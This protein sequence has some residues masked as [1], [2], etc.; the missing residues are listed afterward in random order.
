MQREDF[1]RVI[2]EQL[3]KHGYTQASLAKRLHVSAATVN[4]W[5]KG[6]NTIP[7]E[8]ILAISNHW[9]LTGAEQE[10]LFR[11]A[12][13]PL[14]PRHGG[15]TG[16]PPSTVEVLSSDY[17]HRPA[18]FAT[19][20]KS[21]LRK[22]ARQLTA[23]TSALKG[24]GGYGK[25]TLAKA[26]CHDPEIQAAF[27]DG[28][29]WITLGEA[30]K[31]GELIE[32]IKD[33]IY[34][35]TQMRPP[36]ESLEVANAELCVALE[37]RCLLLVVDDVWFASD[38]NP[39]LQ[40]GQRCARLVTTRNEGILPPSIP[41]VQV[42]AMRQEEAVQLLYHRV[43][44]SDDFNRHERA[45]YNLV[46]RL[47][48]WPLLIRL[49]NGILRNR[50]QK[51]N[52]ALSAALAYLE[53]ELDKHGV[54]AF[55]P[56]Q[57]HERHDAVARTLKISFAL[58]SGD[59]YARY[60]KLAIFPEDAEIPFEMV[61]RLWN[62]NDALDQEDVEAICLRLYDLSLLH[63]I[64]L[65]QQYIQLHDV[66]R[67]YLHVK[68]R[69]TL[70]LL[71]QEFLST[72]GLKRWAELSS[73]DT[74]LWKHLIS[75]LIQAKQPDVLFET[76]TDIRYL[77]KKISVYHSAYAAE[78][79]IEYA[80]QA[81]SEKKE[82][83]VLRELLARIGDLLYLCE[84]LSELE[85]M[86]LLYI[87][88]LED[89]SAQCQR[90]R[91]EI[92]RPYLLPWYPFPE[93]KGADL[94]RTL[95]GHTGPVTHCALS[96]D[97]AWI[98]SASAD[99][100]LNVWNMATGALRLTLR[101]HTS[102]ITGCAI[103]PDGSRIISTSEDG[104]IRIWNAYSGSEL[105]VLAEHQGV[106][107]GCALSRDGAWL[108]TTSADTTIKLWDIRTIYGPPTPQGYAV[109]LRYTLQGHD[110]LV[111]SCAFSA[112]GS[113]LV[114]ASED[115]TL[116][117]W[118]IE[119]G[120][121]ILPPV[122][123][124]ETEDIIYSCA[125]SADGTCLIFT[126]GIGLA[127]WD[128]PTRTERFI[129]YGHP[130]VLLGCAL[131][132][133][134]RW[135]LSASVDGSIKGW[136]T[137]QDVDIFILL[138]HADSVNYCA[139][140]AQSD[141][142][143]SASDDHTL[144]IWS[145]PALTAERLPDE[146][147]FAFAVLGCAID[148]SGN[149]AASVAEN[150]E[151]KRWNLHQIEDQYGLTNEAGASAK[152]VISP[153]GKWIATANEYSL[154]LWDA[155]T[156][157]KLQIFQG[158]TGTINHCAIS[159]DGTWLVTASDDQTLRIWDRDTGQEQ[160]ILESHTGAV[161]SCAISADGKR[162]VSASDDQTLNIWDARTGILQ[163]TLRGH[164]E[165]VKD[166]AFTPAGDTIVSASHNGT[167][168]LWNVHMPET[169]PRIFR[170]ADLIKRCVIS[171]DGK[172]LLTLTSTQI[173]LWSLSTGHC[174][175]TFYVRQSLYDCAFHPDGQHFIAAA[176]NGL[177]LLFLVYR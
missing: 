163:Q 166:C 40:G 146:E 54:T 162:I 8:S 59:D 102:A 75:H 104:T 3:K 91:Q 16:R 164:A 152:C 20:K 142:V 66:I 99:T 50:V 84:S 121:Q 92:A 43:G 175:T 73:E 173:K 78:S 57:P 113:L 86:L 153:D 9:Q 82:L 41:G 161:N 33:L 168:R 88:Q 165:E 172:L 136:L 158:H 177:Y 174:L 114:S 15:T 156:G 23:I 112:N 80:M 134:E 132:P 97:G 26:L 89:F 21:I 56:Y 115:Q 64:D 101:G 24:A 95:R 154:T 122:R 68:T 96:S 170:Q 62:T 83:N 46:Q 140:N 133:D 61:R 90:F 30:L 74:Y 81:L 67:A 160:H 10:E 42:D 65:T 25:T 32:K 169:T 28:I 128:V 45:L 143:I 130:G 116:R 117:F 171:P 118:H 145:V 123:P 39:F 93:R 60:L 17:V 51:H 148:P 1:E 110:G 29:E 149:W 129:A 176:E 167:I 159:P 5:L 151:L 125:I 36:V 103:T 6:P 71:Q 77:A 49:V 131:S 147:E 52:Q 141:R 107:T 111:T 85:S 48:E 155:S 137:T 138:G 37:G 31:P 58:L 94:V 120:Q 70:P 144:K 12:G 35:L 135:M 100:T 105:L 14:P 150:G 27:P 124:P 119:T 13:Y 4:K 34:R 2:K 72:C 76:V 19:L 44:S 63:S 7:Y 22:E 79:D 106:V 47:K 18:E 139:I 108:A 87:S 98:V 53:H 157:A 109:S 55:D 38:L 11:A 126:Y 127:V 69:Q